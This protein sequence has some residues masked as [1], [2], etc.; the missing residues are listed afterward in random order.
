MLYVG[1][2]GYMN[3]YNEGVEKQSLD[4]VKKD[5]RKRYG[6]GKSIPEGRQKLEGCGSSQGTYVESNLSVTR[7]VI[8]KLQGLIIMNCGSC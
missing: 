6:S 1:H 8:K 7:Q 2:S 4:R 5:K 3:G